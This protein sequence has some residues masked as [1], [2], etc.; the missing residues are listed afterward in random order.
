VTLCIVIAVAF[1]LV[2]L[3][4]GLDHERLNRCVM[5]GTRGGEKHHRDCPWGNR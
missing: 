5:C 4:A 2:Y 1:F 3:Q